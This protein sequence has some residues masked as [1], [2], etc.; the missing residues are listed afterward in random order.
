[1]KGSGGRREII[2]EKAKERENKVLRRLNKEAD[3]GEEV[4]AD[5]DVQEKVDVEVW[6]GVELVGDDHIVE[7]K[8]N[9]IFTDKIAN[10]RCG[11]GR[12]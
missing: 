8:T 10:A 7:H 9:A 6:E 1:M 3:G 4:V 12:I 11:S 5:E 2:K